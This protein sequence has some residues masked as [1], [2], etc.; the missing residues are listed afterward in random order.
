[1]D[2]TVGLVGMPR[3]SCFIGCGKIC[4]N[5]D[6]KEIYHNTLSHKY[7]S[8]HV[9]KIIIIAFYSCIQYIVHITST[10]IV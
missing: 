3:H 8:I 1:M 6:V 10:C 9:H 4:N 7:D 5:A 2:A